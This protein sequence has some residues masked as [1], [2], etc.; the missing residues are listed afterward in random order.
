ML[1]F[2]VLMKL[3]GQHIF[4]QF[5]TNGME[6]YCEE[7]ETKVDDTRNAIADVRQASDNGSLVY[8]P[9]NGGTRLHFLYP[10]WINSHQPESRFK[11][12]NKLRSAGPVDGRS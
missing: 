10:T 8:V 4:T 9:K 2:H 3:A 6:P 12:A 7:R 1:K 11:K 5:T